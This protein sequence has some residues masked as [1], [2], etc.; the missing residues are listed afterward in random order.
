MSAIS[1]F[2]MSLSAT[3]LD[4]GD[5]EDLLNLSMEGANFSLNTI[6]GLEVER[7]SDFGRFERMATNPWRKMLSWATLLFNCLWFFRQHDYGLKNAL[8]ANETLVKIADIKAEELKLA[9]SHLAKLQSIVLGMVSA[10]GGRLPFP[11]QIAIDVSETLR[12]TIDFLQENDYI[13]SSSYASVNLSDLMDGGMAEDE[14][15]EFISDFSLV[16]VD[17]TSDMAQKVREL[18]EAI[19]RGEIVAFALN[20]LKEKHSGR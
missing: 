7:R 18:T 1:A 6:M 5:N 2:W 11:G 4:L 12:A 17:E 8:D 3:S 14:A 13:E 15:L 10:L 16:D 20:Y 19:E 9:V